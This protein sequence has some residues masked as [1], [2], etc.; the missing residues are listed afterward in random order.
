MF[1]A[2]SSQYSIIDMLY[3][4]YGIGFYHLKNDFGLSALKLLL[5]SSIFN[6]L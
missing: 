3:C 5:F 2:L 4:H 6:S 1:L